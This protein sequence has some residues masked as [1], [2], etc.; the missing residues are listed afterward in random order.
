[1][2]VLV[3]GA[4]GFVGAYLTEKLVDE[5]H[6]VS[7]LVHHARLREKSSVA[8][9]PGDITDAAS[10]E[11]AVKGCDLVYH[12]AGKVSW[13]ETSKRDYHQV[14]VQGTKNVAQA[15]MKAGAQRLVYVS[16]TG[17]YG[18]TKSCVD[19]TV[20]PKPDSY[21]RATKFLAEQIVLD[22]D[23]KEAVPAVVARIGSVYGPGARSWRPLFKAIAEKRF[24]MIGTG[25]NHVDLVYASD[26]I[27]GISL[28][29][30]ARGSEGKVYLIAGVEPATFKSLVI[31]IAEELGVDYMGEVGTAPFRAFDSFARAAYRVCGY[32]VPQAKRYDLF[33]N[34]KLFDI[35]KARKELGY[36]PKVPLRAGIARSIEWYRKQG[37]L[38]T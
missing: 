34:D 36:E 19:E 2:R 22:Y 5:G 15:A 31:M 10:V 27:D 9:I 26:V 32:Q 7:V 35:S 17:V 21:Y 3:T 13:V 1:M 11:R 12:L 30:N 28:C 23:K 37:D 33:F 29:G 14:N 8:L 4:T 16:T 6:E 24:R 25:E 38:P 18:R 20:K